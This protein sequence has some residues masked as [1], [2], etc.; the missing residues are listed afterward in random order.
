M[1]EK[2]TDTTIGYT[3]IKTI[4][5]GGDTIKRIEFRLPTGND[6]IE[7]GDPVE[8]DFRD[9]SIRI[10]P[11]AMTEMMSRLAG[12]PPSAIKSMDARDWK[13]CAVELTGFFLPAAEK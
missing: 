8:I 12:I 1:E 7:A 9:G 13:G 3:L 4:E 2:K 10:V 11:A 6:I 5:G